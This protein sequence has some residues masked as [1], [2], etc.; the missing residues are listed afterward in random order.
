MSG[1]IP[2]KVM[3]TLLPPTNVKT[4]LWGKPGIPDLMG[5]TFVI[6]REI[7][8]RVNENRVKGKNRYVFPKK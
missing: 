5:K 1:F 7:E 6:R 3:N 4:N 8:K 2:S